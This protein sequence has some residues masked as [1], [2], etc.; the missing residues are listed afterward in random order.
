MTR[1]LLEK[2]TGKNKRI[3]DIYWRCSKL[4]DQKS[5]S[6]MGWCVVRMRKMRTTL[7]LE[8]LNARNTE[9]GLQFKTYLKELEGEVR[10]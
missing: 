4:K 5:K 8:N 6:A 7:Y 1:N 10:G 2:F 3:N 9:R